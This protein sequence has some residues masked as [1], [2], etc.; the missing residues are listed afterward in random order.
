MTACSKM[1]EPSAVSAFWGAWSRV[2]NSVSSVRLIS[3]S[4]Y[5]FSKMLKQESCWHRSSLYRVA[6][7]SLVTQLIVPACSLNELSLIIENPSLAHFV[8]DLQS[9]ILGLSE[10]DG[11]PVDIGLPL[12]RVLVL[13]VEP[14]DL[15]VGLQLVVYTVLLLSCLQ[16]NSD[17]HPGSLAPILF[18]L[19]YVCKVLSHPTHLVLKAD[20]PG[21]HHLKG[22]VRHSLG[23]RVLQLSQSVSHL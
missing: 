23:D 13:Q 4:R 5:I 18:A 6:D 2:S 20:H 1:V 8:D 16:G 3:L 19:V 11:C 21:L 22:E 17:K 14:G 7:G 9:I 10:Q 15:Q 12:H